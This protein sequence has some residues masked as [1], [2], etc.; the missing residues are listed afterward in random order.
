MWCNENI[1]LDTF[2]L[3]TNYTYFGADSN[4]TEKH[5]PLV[6]RTSLLN[7]SLVQQSTISS[8]TVNALYII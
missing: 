2:S 6:S 3:L 8:I 1:P 5:F 7:N 4:L